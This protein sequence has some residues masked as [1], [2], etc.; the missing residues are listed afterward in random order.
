MTELSF[1]PWTDEEVRSLNA[2]Q[3]SR[4]MHPFTCGDN[5]GPAVLL[6]SPWGWDCPDGDCEY[7]QDWAHLWMAN[8]AWRVALETGIGAWVP[9][10]VAYD[11][12]AERL[13]RFPARDD[14][15]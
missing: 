12:D 6:A 8:W 4:A 5:H 2:Y 15:A 13:A 10:C 14:Y 11:P 3:G 9:G 7:T 1:A